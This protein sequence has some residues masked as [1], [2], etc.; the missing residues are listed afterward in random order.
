MAGG[1]V[2][3]CFST[4]AVAMSDRLLSGITELGSTTSLSNAEA[5]FALM[6]IAESG[7]G[8]K[9]RSNSIVRL[10]GAASG[11]GQ[12]L[13]FEFG[14]SSLKPGVRLR[15]ERPKVN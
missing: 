9:R 3:V 2:S 13:G 12:H 4:L 14:F 5:D 7:A 11:A 6:E 10:H 15:S 8:A 1:D